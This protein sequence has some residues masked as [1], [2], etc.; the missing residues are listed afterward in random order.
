M[1]IT[2]LCLFYRHVS[3]PMFQ[4]TLHPDINSFFHLNQDRHYQIFSTDYCRNR[5]FHVRLLSLTKQIVVRRRL[6]FLSFKLHVQCT[7]TRNDNRRLNRNELD[8]KPWWLKINLQILLTGLR[9]FLR[10]QVRM[11]DQKKLCYDSFEAWRVNKSS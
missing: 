3:V 6:T 2:N 9:T 1:L 11:I 10:V 8:F 4:A 5:I 7:D